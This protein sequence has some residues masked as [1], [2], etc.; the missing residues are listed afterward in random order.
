MDDA[1]I[2][3]AATAQQVAAAVAARTPDAP[4]F[5]GAQL[6]QKIA[7]LPPMSIQ[8][9]AP[10]RDTGKLTIGGTNYFDAEILE[11]YK[12]TENSVVFP[13][14]IKYTCKAAVPDGDTIEI[15]TL[16]DT[17]TLSPP[18][19][20]WEFAFYLQNLSDT[21]LSLT[22]YNRNSPTG[23]WNSWNISLAGNAITPATAWRYWTGMLKNTVRAGMKI[24]VKGPVSVGMQFVVLGATCIIDDPASIGSI[25][26]VAAALEANTTA[27]A[28]AGQP[29]ALQDAAGQESTECEVTG[30]GT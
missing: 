30:N 22:G 1:Y 19:V 6:A 16:P 25:D 14:S 11:N 12:L 7:W 2:M 29:A 17:E 20:R 10:F 8:E 3:E 13:H 28:R 23:T 5:S 18:C 4:S 27:K 26:M 24:A 15:L 9:G 21:D